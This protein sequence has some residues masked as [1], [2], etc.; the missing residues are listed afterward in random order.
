[1]PQ[2]R[3]IY[4]LYDQVPY[5]AGQKTVHCPACGNLLYIADFKSEKLKLD[6]VKKERDQAKQALETAQTEKQQADQRL[7]FA[8]K[9]LENIET[10]QQEGEIDL[11]AL[12]SGMEISRENQQAMES[13]LRGLVESNQQAE[14]Q[15][16]VI[17]AL[18]QE[19]M[20]SQG[21]A[22]QKLQLLEILCG[23]IVNAQGSI[24]DQ[25]GLQTEIVETLRGMR[26]EIGEREQLIMEFTRWNQSS[27]QEDIKRLSQVQDA[28]EQL[29]SSQQQMGRQISS[30]TETAERKEKE[31]QQFHQQWQE[32][33]QRKKEELY[34]QAT[35]DQLDKKFLE[36]EKKYNQVLVAG[37][38]SIDIY[39]RLVLCHYGVEYLYSEAE[40]RYVPTFYY[41]D[42]EHAPEEMSIWK[43]LLQMIEGSD[44][45]A[46]YSERITE[47]KEILEAYRHIHLE[48]DKPY[49]VFISVK[50]SDAHGHYTPDSDR[51]S[52]LYDTLTGWG[53]KVFNS[54][55]CM[56]KHAGIRYEPYILA[57]LM[58]A[59]VMIVVGTT[60]EYMEA[61]W[62]KNEW[63]RYS[64]L[65]KNEKK[66][67]PS[68][69]RRLLLCYLA[70]GM[71]ARDIPAGLNPDKQAI[72]EG[73]KTESALQKVLEE[74][75]GSLKDEPEA[76]S[77]DQV[78]QQMRAW[79]ASQMYEN[80]T[81]KYNQVIRQGKYTDSPELH[82]L[83]LCARR[84]VNSIEKLSQPEIDLSNE[85][86]Y[87]LARSVAQKKKSSSEIKRLDALLKRNAENRK[88]EKDGSQ[89]KETKEEKKPITAWKY[90]IPGII[91]G[92]VLIYFAVRSI[93]GPGGAPATE[94]TDIP[95]STLISGDLN[96]DGV[97]DMADILS[98]RS[99]LAKKHDNP[100]L[101]YDIT[102]DKQV[103]EADLSALTDMVNQNNHT[104]VPGDVNGDG[105]VNMAD[106]ILLSRYLAGEDVE[107][108]TDA[109]DLTGDGKIDQED[110][111][112]LRIYIVSQNSVE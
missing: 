14:G 73:V 100:D 3:C 6:A 93:T 28:A 111:E 35:N 58:T 11:N 5:E 104:T 40:N 102:G 88:A 26:L 37:E 36:A 87:S 21:S 23:K 4:C 108:D 29:L 8:L 24:L 42:I 13:L 27:H 51:A 86:L 41:P 68:A 55:R 12:L 85:P 97:V 47:L 39:W 79:L 62:V 81:E 71:E 33:E 69:P 95:A 72:R 2:E 32:S 83:A 103:D 16:D 25:M 67:T 98:M 54:R 65:E 38:K 17:T 74:V 18:L 82:L 20:K 10:A 31:L 59:K 19:T 84:H 48:E 1:M 34:R 50:Q 57:A 30:L 61:R 101:N 64:W 99:Y 63:Q 80:A 9:K 90:I 106:E 45:K 52:D 44:N 96:R 107:I 46:E 94:K 56:D 70:G 109:C 49:D 66:I 91:V 78:L 89:E 22:D 112:S 105:L 53:L 15:R 75:F 77:V 76:E 7:F 60:K 43:N 110:L 92:V